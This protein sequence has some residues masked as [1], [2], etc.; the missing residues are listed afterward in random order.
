MTKAEIEKRM[1]E[2][3]QELDSLKA[4]LHAPEKK[5]GWEKPMLGQFYW[6]FDNNLIKYAY[7]MCVPD[8]NRYQIGNCF[9]SKELAEN[10]A[11]TSLLTSESEGV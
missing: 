11:R 4:Q 9:T 10:I 8:E 2:I 3:Q 1:N 5:T 7:T 6:F